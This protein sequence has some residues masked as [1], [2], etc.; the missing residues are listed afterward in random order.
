MEVE[1][2]NRAINNL[3]LK[4][5]FVASKMG[6]SKTALSL[7]LNGKSKMPESRINQIK[8]ILNLKK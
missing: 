6:I 7:W 8:A 5:G 2:I 1:E 3:G 4:K